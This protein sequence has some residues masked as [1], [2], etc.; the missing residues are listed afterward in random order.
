M[1]VPEQDALEKA[2]GSAE[3][4]FVRPKKLLILGDQSDI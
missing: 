4:K 3:D 2:T 1:L